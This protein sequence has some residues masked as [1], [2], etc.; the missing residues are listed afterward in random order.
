[1]SKI[2]RVNMT[3]L[4]TKLEDVPEKYREWGGR[5]LTSAIT[6][7]EVIPTC[8]PLGPNNK[9][10]FAPGIVTGTSAPTSAR[11]SVGAKSPLTGGIK[12]ANAGSGFPPSL[13]RMGI[14]AIIIEGQ[15]EE[16]DQYW[17]MHLTPHRAGAFLNPAVCPAPGSL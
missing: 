15:P 4:T 8:N 1:M 16:K 5:G 13:A 6:C 17:L 7:D 11:I 2:L 14:R 3:N 12:E 9:V 10:T